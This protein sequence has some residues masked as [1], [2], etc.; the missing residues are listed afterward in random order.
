MID[1]CLYCYQNFST[2]E[3]KLDSV[4]K[5]FHP[6]CSQ[7]NFGKKSPPE[8]PYT[9]SE[10]A[11]L[12]ESVVKSH[13]T[14]TGVQ[15]K[16]SLG[17]Q[18]M[19]GK[20]VPDRFTIVGLWGNYILKPPTEAYRNLPE[21]ESLTMKLAEISKIPTVNFSLIYL[22][23]GELAYITKREDRVK[24]K[25][26][27]MEDMCQLTEKLTEHKYRGSY[28]QIAKAI[29]KYSDNP[30]LNLIHFYRQVIFSFLTGNTDMHLKNFSL[31]KNINNIYNLCPAYDMVSSSLVL[32]DPDELALTLNGKK[33]K[34]KLQD[35][36]I[37]MEKSGINLKTID[38]V[39]KLFKTTVSQW[40]NLIDI[41]FLPADLKEDYKKII[42]ENSKKIELH[43]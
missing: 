38:N 36:Y 13:I 5:G 11:D 1:R 25:K 29:L 31:L 21:N 42:S 28:E 19:R 32:S 33:R 14:V 6:K 22:K 35:F 12:A 16:L 20:D 43:N 23:S 17:L 39:F 3:K 41:S 18:K 26:L 15:P 24:G 10:I 40:N 30:G 9:I 37:S 4:T 8:L 2:E 7:K 34:L 27:H